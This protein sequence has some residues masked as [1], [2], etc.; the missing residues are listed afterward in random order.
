MKKIFYA[1]F[2]VLM[3]LPL[4]SISGADNLFFGPKAFDRSQ[5][6][7]NVFDES[8]TATSNNG[9]LLVFNGDD[10]QD[11]RVTS[12]SIVLNGQEVVSSSELN[13]D[14]D[15]ITKGVN[16]QNDNAMQITLDGDEGVG[17]II[18]MVVKDKKNIPEFTAGRIHLA[19]TTIS[20]P[21][22]T[23]AV[24]LKNGSPNFDRHVK[25]RFFNEDGS[26][27]AL[28]SELVLSKHASLNSTIQAL[29]PQGATWNTGSLEILFAGRG[30]A[31]VLGYGLQ[32]TA[33]TE[34]AIPLQPGGIRHNDSPK[35]NK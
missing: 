17:Y 7:P 32:T 19:W 35:K 12:G 34:T 25:V 29:L 22:V 26:L 5:G 4:V 23:V 6:S 15:R 3:L 16:L 10:E 13:V 28:S 14:T 18:V 8:F 11:S 30:G 1:G 31:R 24:R 27:A 20:D 21:S 33:A 2:L 9:F